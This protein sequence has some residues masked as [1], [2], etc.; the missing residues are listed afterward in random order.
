MPQDAFT[1]RLSAKELD[2]ALRGG[3]IS[4]IVQPG[5]EE[6][7]LYIYTQKTTLKL[8]L[9]VNASDCG[10]YFTERDAQRSSPYPSSVSSG[11]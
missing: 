1:L 11:S 10:V 6:T 3:K 2:A 9:N 5:R 4:K 7:V 8:I